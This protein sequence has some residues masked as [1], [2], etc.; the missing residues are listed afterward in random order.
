MNAWWWS[1]LVFASLIIGILLGAGLTLWYFARQIRKSMG[2]KSWKEFREKMKEAQ[3]LQ[4][5]ME[6]GHFRMDEDLRKKMEEIAK[7]FS[8]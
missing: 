4:K 3:K 8:Q 2:I 1:L 5:Q 7:R 6:K